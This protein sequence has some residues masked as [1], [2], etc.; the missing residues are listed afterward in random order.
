M[1]N[2]K[3]ARKINPDPYITIKQRTAEVMLKDTDMVPC[4]RSSALAENKSSCVKV[5][6]IQLKFICKKKMLIYI[7]LDVVM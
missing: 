1:L 4:I 2:C 5:D 6:I 7:N 3:I